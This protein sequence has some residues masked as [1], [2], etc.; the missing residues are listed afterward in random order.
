M[1]INETLSA[2]DI[3]KTLSAPVKPFVSIV[4]S[5]YNEAAILENNLKVLCRYM[6]SLEDRYDWEMI[7][8]NDG[9]TDATGE[10]LDRFAAGRDNVTVLHHITNFGLGQALQFAFGRCRGDYVVTVDIDLSYSPDHIERLLD[11]IIETR[12]KIVIASPYTSGGSVSNVPLLRKFLSISANRF[13]ALVSRGSFTGN[14]LPTSLYTL[15]SMVRAYDGRFLSRLNLMV[16]GMGISPEI[17]HK[18]MILRARI[19]EIPA[20]L[21]WGNEKKEGGKQRRSSMRIIKNIVSSFITGF[22]FRPFVFFVLPG[23]LLLTFCLYSFFFVFRHVFD[24]YNRITPSLG[25]IDYRLGSAV[26]DAFE[27]APHAFIIGGITLIVSIQLIQMGILSLQNKRYFEELFHLG[28]SIYDKTLDMDFRGKTM[29]RNFDETVVSSF[30]RRFQTG[31]AVQ[32]G[33]YKRS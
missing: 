21:D 27:R 14:F 3:G 19:V 23:L 29:I 32:P 10:I 22:M 25:P 31:R 18:A 13:L 20:H 8:V 17:I 33:R 26:S 9:S 24:C 2:D 12:A 30:G 28:T 5:A 6:A 1:F 11:K 7:V 15:T 4:A 16:T